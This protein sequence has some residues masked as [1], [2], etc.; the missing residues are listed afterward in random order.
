MARLCLRIMGSGSIRGSKKPMLELPGTQWGGIV[1][2]E[3]SIVKLWKLADAGCI[4]DNEDATVKTLAYAQ[5]DY[6][7]EGGS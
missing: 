2:L 6:V 3:E 1:E 5:H 7:R 4:G